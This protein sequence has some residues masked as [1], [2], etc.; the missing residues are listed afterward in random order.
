MSSTLDQP[1]LPHRH[2]ILICSY[3]RFWKILRSLNKV[4]FRKI[5]QLLDILSAS[6]RQLSLLDLYY[7]DE[8][9]PE[10]A[11]KAPCRFLTVEQAD[12]QVDIMPRRVNAYCKG[13]LEETSEDNSQYPKLTYAHRSVKDFLEKEEVKVEL[14]AA[15]G[16]DF[17]PNLR[18]CNAYIMGLS[19][20]GVPTFITAEILAQTGNICV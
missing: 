18:L 19:C 4:H 7:T 15:T 8:E 2:K 16:K 5:S 6:I 14:N 20:Q 17:N 13:L 11:I 12:S 10:Y 9:N 3:D 1:V